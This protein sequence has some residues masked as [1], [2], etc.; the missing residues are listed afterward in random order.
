MPHFDLVIVGTGSGNT[1]AGKEYQDLTIAIVESGRFGGTCLNVGCIPT[2]SYV[3]PADIAEA[4]RQGGRLGVHAT[5]DRV[6]WRGMRDR[7]F[8]RIDE[9]SDSG[10]QYREG[11]KWPN[12]TVFSGTG[13]FT[14]AKRMVVALNDGGS[15]ELTAD[16]FVL[17]A[18]G[19]PVIPDIPGLDEETIGRDVVHTSDTIMRIDELPERLVVVG[20]GYIAAEF[21]HIFASFGTRITQLVRGNRLLRHHDADIATT[22]TDYTQQRYDLRRDTDVCGI[23]PTTSAGDGVSVFVEGPYGDAVVEADLLLVATG[24]RPNTDRLNLGATGVTLDKYGSV[25]VDA[26]QDNVVPGFY[27]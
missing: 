26:Y 11:P 9:I 14:G 18:G 24:R 21:A 8:A 20:G 5:V 12:L 6:D 27:A 1:I 4:A 7:I 2:K 13:R 25:V 22:F 3:Y 19:R 16:R 10:Q 15:A 17:A 23:K